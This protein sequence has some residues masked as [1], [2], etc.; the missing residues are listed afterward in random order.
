MDFNKP[1]EPTPSKVEAASSEPDSPR[2]GPAPV[3]PAL[4]RRKG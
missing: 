3:V 2:R 4:F 1:Y